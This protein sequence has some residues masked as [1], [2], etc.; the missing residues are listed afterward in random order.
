LDIKA[1]TGQAESE[2]SVISDEDPKEKKKLIA[3]E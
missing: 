2:E 3:E 1:L